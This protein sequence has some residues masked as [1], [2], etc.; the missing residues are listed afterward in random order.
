MGMSGEPRYVKSIDRGMRVRRG[1]EWAWVLEAD[2]N[3]LREIL[4]EFIDL[5]A[6]TIP[7]DALLVRQPGKGDTIWRKAWIDQVDDKPIRAGN[8][9][10]FVPCITYPW[11]DTH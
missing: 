3:K 7:A 9:A 11:E 1:T 10:H 6:E 5:P 8:R 4:Q 2:A